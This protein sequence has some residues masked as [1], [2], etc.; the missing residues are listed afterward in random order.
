MHKHIEYMF[1]FFDDIASLTG[2]PFEILNNGFRVVNFCN[3]AVYV[4]GFQNVIEFTPTVLNIK[5]KKGVV[6]LSG[7]GLKIKNLSQNTIVVS[8]KISSLEIN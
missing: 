8:G 4:E 5:L 6:K 1:S 7:L 3:K 2:L